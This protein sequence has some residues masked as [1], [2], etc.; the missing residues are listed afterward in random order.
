MFSSIILLVICKPL[1]RDPCISFGIMVAL[2]LITTI[3]LDLYLSSNFKKLAF[4]LSLFKNSYLGKHCLFM[5]IRQ[6]YNYRCSRAWGTPADNLHS[7]QRRRWKIN[8]WIE[9]DQRKL[10]KDSVTSRRQRS[11][12]CNRL[13][14]RSI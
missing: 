8:S 1:S 3:K 5:N 6:L 2:R 11:F 7:K 13:N 10:R 4:Y 12:C 9:T 14:R